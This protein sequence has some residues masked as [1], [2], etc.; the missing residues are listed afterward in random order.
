MVKVMSKR[1]TVN[2]PDEVA[3]RLEREDNVSAYVTE[4][5]LRRMRGE[6]TRA[7]LEAAGFRLTEEGMQKWR[8]RLA[9][10][11]AK[12]TPEVLARGK[13]WLRQRGLDQ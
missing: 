13:E 2:V 11:R 1:V 3:V 12:M 10:G 7:M 4:A 8:E 5:I 6:T 9:E